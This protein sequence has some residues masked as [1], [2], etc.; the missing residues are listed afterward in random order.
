MPWVEVEPGVY[1]EVEEGMTVSIQDLKDKLN[2]IEEEMQEIYSE[3][4]PVPEGAPDY[5]REA[6][7]LYNHTT[8]GP[9]L[10]EL[11]IEKQRILK[12]LREIEG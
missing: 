2:S 12:I 5:V 1:K 9:R 4:K 7:E 3:F 6:V 8:Y 11:E 10:A